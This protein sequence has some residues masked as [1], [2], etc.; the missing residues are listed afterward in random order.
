MTDF[1]IAEQRLS[2]WLYKHA[3]ECPSREFIGD[4]TMVLQVAKD[5]S[6]QQAEVKQLRMDLARAEHNLA[7]LIIERRQA[8]RGGCGRGT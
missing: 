6:K 5:A 2:R 4:I 3:D 8:T 7:E 1:E